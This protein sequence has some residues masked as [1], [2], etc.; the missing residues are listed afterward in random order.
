MRLGHQARQAQAVPVG[1]VD[2]QGQEEQQVQQVLRGL[3]GLLGQAV[4][5]APQGQ[6]LQEVQARQDRV[7]PR[8]RLVLSHFNLLRTIQYFLTKP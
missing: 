7:V 3:L 1:L 4:P 8:V 6:D 5:Q 2:P